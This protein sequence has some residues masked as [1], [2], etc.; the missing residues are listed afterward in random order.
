LLCAFQRG[1]H[2]CI[3][4]VEYCLA[5]LSD[6]VKAGSFLPRDAMLA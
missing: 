2:I 6:I 1:E 3:I 4:L 5:I